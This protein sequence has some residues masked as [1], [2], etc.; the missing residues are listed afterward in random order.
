MRS[1]AHTLPPCGCPLVPQVAAANPVIAAEVSYALSYE[2]TVLCDG[3][4]SVES[5]SP[6]QQ[7][8]TDNGLVVTHSENGEGCGC[9]KKGARA[10]ARGCGSSACV[11]L[12][13]RGSCCAAVNIF[14]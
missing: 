9:W 5:G 8:R 11:G 3:E 7:R 13:M 1:S 2:V 14:N 10:A 6:I 12:D 4:V